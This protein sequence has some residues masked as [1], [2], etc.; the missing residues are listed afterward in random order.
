MPSGRV[1][2]QKHVLDRLVRMPDPSD[3]PGPEEQ[4]VSD[5]AVLTSGITSFSSAIDMR[6][7]YD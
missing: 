5:D 6:L 1:V 7:V 2:E 3:E 4:L